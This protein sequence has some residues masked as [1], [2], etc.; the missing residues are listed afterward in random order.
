M[1]RG[2]TDANHLWY[3]SPL[4]V[5]TRGQ[6]EFGVHFCYRIMRWIG[7]TIK[8]FW[9]WFVQIWDVYLNLIWFA[10][11]CWALAWTIT[12]GCASHAKRC[13]SVLG[14]RP[15]FE[16]HGTP[17]CHQ[18]ALWQLSCLSS[19]KVQKGQQSDTLKRFSTLMSFAHYQMITMVQLCNR[20]CTQSGLHTTI[21]TARSTR[22]LLMHVG[23]L[24][25]GG[26]LHRPS[27]T[28]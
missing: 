27:N 26:R 2:V 1:S 28:K 15:T 25:Q 24:G 18:S 17:K 19:C 16:S 3:A 13:K 14:C 8:W 9:H 20:W 10:I 23:I 5:Q 7:L 21:I 6:E 11:A 22:S 4:A 12:M